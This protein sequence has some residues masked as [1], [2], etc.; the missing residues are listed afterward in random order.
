MCSDLQSA[1]VIPAVWLPSRN[2]DWLTA[3]LV[4][5]VFSLLSPDCQIEVYMQ[6]ALCP[7]RLGLMGHCVAC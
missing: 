3:H 7:F 6:Y 2:L 5:S 4:A 1:C